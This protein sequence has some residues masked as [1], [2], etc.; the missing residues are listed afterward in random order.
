MIYICG[1]CKQPCDLIARIDRRGTRMYPAEVTNLTV[2][3]H[4][5]DF[6]EI[7]EYEYETVTGEKPQSSRVLSREDYREEADDTDD[8]D[9]G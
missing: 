2:C 4:V 5:E 9:R 1:K 3:C 8:A 6:D 7:T